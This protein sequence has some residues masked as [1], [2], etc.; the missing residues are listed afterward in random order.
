MPRLLQRSRPTGSSAA[1][2]SFSGRA[3][4]LPPYEEPSCPLNDAGKRALQDLRNGREKR[5]YEAH[6]IKSAKFLQESV[7]ATNDA[8]YRRQK[9][10]AM[11]KAKRSTAGGETD[12]EADEELARLEQAAADLE[13]E[14]SQLT[15]RTEAAL[16]RVI[17]YAAEL[18]DEGPVLEEVQA[19]VNAQKPRPEPKT[20]PRRQRNNDG[21]DSNEENEED[22]E[23]VDMDDADEENHHI[24]GVRDMLKTARQIKQQ[25][26]SGLSAHQRYGQNND[27]IAFKKTW[28]DAQHPDD[29][30]PLPDAST[31]FDDQGRP[32]KGVVAANDDDDLVVERE[33]RDLKCPLSLQMMKDPY[34]NHK[35]KHTFEKSAIIDYLR[36]SGGQAK[37]PVCNQELRVLDLYPD[38][39]MLRRIKRAE[40]ERQMNLDTSDAEEDVDPDVSVI[41]GRTNRVIKKENRRAGASDGIDDD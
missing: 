36:S 21:D 23:D 16:R 26:Y 18:Q 19:Q 7:G 39:V 41:A 25:E 38:P 30:V 28:H 27:Y 37:C 9:N 22:P 14:V 10:V 4:D 2:S 15:D 40:R 35:C 32:V 11:R 34:S 3:V 12:A 5:L 24:A 8:L 17:D 6:L 20:R 31:W 1:S 29:S 13:V 33:I